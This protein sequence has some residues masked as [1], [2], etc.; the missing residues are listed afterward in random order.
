MN[1]LL[2]LNIIGV[3]LVFTSLFMLAPALV[4]YLYG[5]A[6]LWA[7]LASFAVTFVAGGLMFLATRRYWKEE[8]GHRDSFLVVTLGWIAMALAGALPFLISGEIP[9][10]TDAVFESMS[11]FTT[12]G[13]SILT[14]VEALSRGVLFWRSLTHWVGGLGIIV[15][16]VAVLPMM[17]A[18]GN[19]LFRAEISQVLPDKLKPRII[20][21]AKTLWKIY[22]VLTA[23][24][25]VL[26]RLGGMDIYDS[27]CHAFGAVGTGGFSTKN[28]SM[29]YYE[30][31][32]IRYVTV[33]LMFAGGTSFALHYQAL[34]G[35]IGRYARDGEFVFYFLVLSA[36]TML[37]TASVYRTDYDSLAVSFREALFQVVS[38]ATATGFATADFEKWPV[39]TQ[40][41]LLGLM[42]IGGMAGSTAGGM[43]QVRALLS[44]KQARREIHHIIHPHAVSSIRLGD[45]VLPKE[46]L[47]SVWGFIFLF[48]V[49]WTFATLGLAALGVDPVTA[50]ST[51]ISAMSNV[52]PALGE[53]GPAENFASL[54]AAG[55]W[56]L[57]FCMLLGRLEVYTVLVLFMP[58]FWRK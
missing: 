20:D 53:A 6:D 36:A 5:S 56:I 22:I 42:F 28:L 55:K 54:P 7:I 29:G 41:V 19:Q 2:A 38:I 25:V 57:T 48:L 27:F 17:G 21:T 11:G 43:K 3:V 35:G 14:D 18:G 52:G 50:A 51:A 47:G 9:S 24:G 34:R 10:V 32:Y 13:S 49:A 16:F 15:F 8:I 45:R 44:F 40:V 23:L 26:L 46:L 4:S 33:F 39:F 1:A 58:H 31:S 12:T 30:S 37:I